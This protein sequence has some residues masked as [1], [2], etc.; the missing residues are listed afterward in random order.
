[1]PKPHMI[2]L[3][4]FVTDIDASLR[5]YARLGLETTKHGDSFARVSA[6]GEVMIELGTQALTSS[7]DPKHQHP[8]S[9]SKGT[10]NFEFESRAAVEETYK[11]MVAEGYTGHLAPIDAPWQARF[12]IVLDPDGNQIGL[13]SPR[14]NN[15]SNQQETSH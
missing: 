5:F 11:A 7:Y 12:A 3:Y 4:L 15:S 9:N 14:Q 6:Q 10:L 1:M 8:A 13:H 2:G